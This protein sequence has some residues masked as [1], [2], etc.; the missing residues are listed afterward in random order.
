MTKKDDIKP[1]KIKL[2]DLKGGVDIPQ[3]I[4]DEKTKNFVEE[5][6]QLCQKYERIIAPTIQLLKLPKKND[7]NINNIS[8]SQ[9][10]TK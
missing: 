8:D 6:Q 9:P 10:N 1:P 5:Y 3:A 2:E 7:N 4:E